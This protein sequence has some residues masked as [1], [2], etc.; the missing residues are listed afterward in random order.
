MHV[1]C[2]NGRGEN[3]HR[4]LSNHKVCEN[5]YSPSKVS[6]YTVNLTISNH[7]FLSVDLFNLLEEIIKLGHFVEV[8][9][10]QATQQ[11][12]DQQLHT[13][14]QACKVAQWEVEHVVSKENHCLLM[15]RNKI[16]RFSLLLKG[17]TYIK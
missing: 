7:Y 11:W 13:T 16:S 1:A 9:L 17:L 2:L 6:H 5:N 10:K 3:F 4:W 12:S 15:S 14:A 8:I